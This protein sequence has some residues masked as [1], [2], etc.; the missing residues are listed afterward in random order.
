MIGGSASRDVQT[1]RWTPLGFLG[2]VRDITFTS[3]GYVAVGSA[4]RPTAETEPD[5]VIWDG[6]VWIGTTE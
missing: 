2:Q 1:K 5:L 3:A 4:P 6:A